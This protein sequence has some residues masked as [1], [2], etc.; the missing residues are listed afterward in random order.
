[1]IIDD[2]RHI[3]ISDLKKWRYLEMNSVKSGV[4]NWRNRFD[5]VTSSINIKTVCYPENKYLQLQYKC[6]GTDYNYKVNFLSVPSNLGFGNVLYFECPYTKKR[7]RKLHLI[8]SVFMH[9]SALKYGIYESQTRSKSFRLLYQVSL[10][11]F[12]LDN[13][14]LELYTSN[15]KKYYKG[16]KTKKY[17]RILD[18][19]KKIEGS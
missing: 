9:R 4:L 8:N 6:N 13:L 11:F 3:N 7:C 16:K 5:E 2:L 1:M 10:K 18:K 12:E 17:K 19:I 14:Y 15:F